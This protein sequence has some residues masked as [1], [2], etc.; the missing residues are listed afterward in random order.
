MKEEL[1]K[2]I[3]ELREQYSLKN[4]LSSHKKIPYNS[5]KL[6]TKEQLLKINNSKNIYLSNRDRE[7]QLNFNYQDPEAA[8]CIESYSKQNEDPHQTGGAMKSK[9]DLRYYLTK[10]KEHKINE[11]NQDKDL[12]QLKKTCFTSSPLLAEINREA[13]FHNNSSKL[14]GLFIDY[15]CKDSKEASFE[16]RIPRSSCDNIEIINENF[17]IAHT[18]NCG[19]S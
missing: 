6:T 1:N 3:N 8:A 15:D 12:S 11:E 13:S 7:D 16:G 2:N 18:E 17:E 4:S 19:F 10:Q 5:N 9:S 14:K